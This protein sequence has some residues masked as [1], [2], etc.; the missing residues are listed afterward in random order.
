ML[1]LGSLSSAANLASLYLDH[2]LLTGTI[3]SVSSLTK[4]ASF[5]LTENRLTGCFLEPTS[6]VF[7]YCSVGGYGNEVCV[8]GRRVCDSDTAYYCG[9]CSNPTCPSS[10][11]ALPRASAPSAPITAPPAAGSCSGSSSPGP[12][13]SPVTSPAAV[14]PS[15]VS[16]PSPVAG[17]PPP[18]STGTLDA[19]E[20]TALLEMATA[21]PNLRSLRSPWS[22]TNATGACSWTGVYCD[23]TKRNVIEI[24]LNSYCLD[25][26]SSPRSPSISIFSPGSA[27]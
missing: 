7:T 8:C 9:Q 2:N 18:I 10:Y 13:P 23:L 26:R 27:S 20:A 25:V 6:P 5:Y 3:P 21:I 11:G 16:S 4:L 1:S 22:K 19:S 24:N 17:S 15:L 12:A 14:A